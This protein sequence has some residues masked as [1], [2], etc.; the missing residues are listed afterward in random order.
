MFYDLFWSNK[1]RFGSIKT[2]SILGKISIKSK[3]FVKK[4][5][6]TKGVIRNIKSKKGRQY[7]SQKK[8]KRTNKDS[9][10]TTQKTKDQVT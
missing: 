3:I 8:I 10:N 5:E 1:I 9:Q 6:D 4:F 2:V 7:N